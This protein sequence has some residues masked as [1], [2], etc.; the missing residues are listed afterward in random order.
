MRTNFKALC[1]DVG[2]AF[3]S[4]DT[5]E[6]VNFIAGREFG[7]RQGMTVIIKKTLYG[8]ASSA[9]CFHADFDDTLRVFGFVP[10]HFDN[11]VLIHLNKDKK[12]YKYIRSHVD[13]FCIFSRDPKLIMTQIKSVFT[14]KSQGPPEYYLG[15]DFKKDQ[16]GRWCIGSKTYIKEGI[17]RIENMFGTLI[18]HD[19]PMVSGD[20]LE[21]DESKHLNDEEHT[22]F[23]MLIGMLNWIVTIGRIDIAFAVSSL[24]R[25][26]A[27]PRQGHIDRALYVFGYLKKYPNRRIRTDSRNPTVVVNGAEGDLEIDI[28]KKLME[29]YPDAKEQNDNK[30]PV[31]LFD[32]LAVSA[33]VDSD[34]AHDKV[35]RRSITGIIIFVGR[36]PVFALSRRQGA[37][38]T[39]TY[40]AEFM[41]MK[42]AVEEVMSVRYML[43]CLG[44]KVTRPTPIL[45]DNRSVIMNTTIPS[46]LLKK[47]H[48]AISYHMTREAT[49]AGIGRPLKTNG[50]WN[51][52]DIC[53]KAQVSSFFLGYRDDDLRLNQEQREH[54]IF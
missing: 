9:A 52:S 48:V 4:A 26:I 25:F 39:S 36:T 32:E 28:F 38:Q 45:G 24:S 49:A 21:L 8:F 27:C 22:K 13:D 1:G 42:T 15:N 5:R 37:I 7:E 33:Y 6:K 51:F 30:L 34:H 47:K 40:S 43:R 10:T 16:K 54:F 29:R 44:V 50:K 17:R 18:K 46:S 19:I 23:Q 41:A 35:S 2:N 31:P 53:T 3:V 11:D 20:H 12:A 14:V